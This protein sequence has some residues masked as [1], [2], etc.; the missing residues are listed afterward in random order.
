MSKKMFFLVLY[1]CQL[2]HDNNTTSM[3]HATVSSIERLL[4]WW[5]PRNKMESSWSAARR[6]R[7]QYVAVDPGWSLLVVLFITLASL[8]CTLPQVHAFGVATPAWRDCL[9]SRSGE[10][11]LPTQP[12]LLSRISSKSNRP[13]RSPSSSTSLSAMIFTRLSDESL[14]V[15]SEAQAQAQTLKVSEVNN[16]CLLAAVVEQ[17]DSVGSSTSISQ[18]LTEWNLSPSKIVH[19]LPQVY[20]T[21]SSTKNASI[22]KLSDFAAAT[23][24]I[25]LPLSTK[26]QQTLVQA[27]Q[28]SAAMKGGVAPSPIEPI[29]I[30]LSLLQYQEI[31]GIPQA[32]SRSDEDCE[33]MEVLWHLD[34]TLEAEDLCASLLQ[35]VFQAQQQQQQQQPQNKDGSS[36]KSASKATTSKKAQPIV[37][38]TGAAMS[39]AKEKARSLLRECGLDLTLLAREGQ[40]DKVH[41][42][43]VE[44]QSMCQ[45]L[46]RRRKN[47]VCLIG[48]A[49]VGK[50]CLVEA[51]AQLLVSET[52]C[53]PALQ[54]HRI[55][56]LEVGAL[57]AGT[58]FRGEF[59]ERLR[60][61]IEILT[62]S[63]TKSILFIDEIHNLVGAGGNADGNLD[64]SNI[65]KPY[66]ARGQ[67]QVIGA[68]TITEYH[69][70][71]AKDAALE[72]RFQPVVVREPTVEET[73]DILQAVLPFYRSH[74]RV[75]FTNEALEAAARLSDRYIN[76]RFLPDK[77][78]DVLDEAGAMATLTRNRTDFEAP[79]VTDKSIT[80]I[81][82]QWTNIPVGKLEMDE[83]DR[84]QLL[85]ANL[86]RRVKGQ[87]RAVRTVSKA[88]RRARTGIRNP[89]RPVASFLF[90]GPTGTGTLE[91]HG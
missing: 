18:T 65:L 30:L 87:T 29:H 28:L 7:A 56:S 45:T 86:G 80:D 46:V 12:S 81:I 27:G 60:T 76:D 79:T 3:I 40:L 6:R 48:E 91:G 68:T 20:R 51:L 42:R 50:T 37:S 5:A 61:I 44:I 47:N 14:S 70:Y 67:L 22:P 57:L 73:V 10:N 21:A 16:G 54:G 82:S 35:N 43:D 19:A 15:L 77:A 26:V 63:R 49:G 90:C 52:D 41:G 53:P 24:Q 69:R 4:I 64:A 88:I 1:H 83:M 59:E 32:A 74:H 34:A 55:I 58:K 25:E 33:A 39:E 38:G 89:R 9:H 36:K 11:L 85:E 8:F 2:L 62:A 84:L 71:I 23:A 66:L 13:L 72:R 75:E 78:I 17:E 31:D